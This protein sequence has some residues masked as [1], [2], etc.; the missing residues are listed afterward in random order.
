VAG[1]DGLLRC[2][3]LAFPVVQKHRSSVPALRLNY[4]S[5]LL[6]YRERQPKAD[7]RYQRWSLLIVKGRCNPGFVDCSSYVNARRNS[8]ETQ[9][10]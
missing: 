2:S 1:W 10:K 7:F 4:P 8:R 6:N 5:V 9:S 3:G